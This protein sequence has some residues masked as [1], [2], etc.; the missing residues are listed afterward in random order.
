[1]HLLENQLGK[2]A[3]VRCHEGKDRKVIFQNR[4][5]AGEGLAELLIKYKNDDPLILALPRGGV[6]VAAEVARKLEVPLDVLIVRK[7]GAPFDSEVALGG[8]CE[9]TDALWNKTLL[10]HLALKPEDLKRALSIEKNKIQEQILLFRQGRR[11]GSLQKKFVILID[12]GLATGATMAAAIQYLK[13]KQVAKIVVAVPVAA[14]STANKLRK[15][16]NEL[17]TLQQKQE[18]GSVGKWY[19]NFEQ[20]SDQDVVKILSERKE[21]LLNLADERFVS[22]SKEKNRGLYEAIEKDMVGFKSERDFDRL[23][24]NVKDKRVVMLGEASHG[25]EEFYLVRRLISQ[26]LIKD[27]GFKFIAVEG[28]WPDAYRLHRYIQR[29]EGLD[30]RSVL[31]H[32]HRWPTWM[33]A[34]EETV[35]L[36]ESLRKSKAGFYGLDVY[37]LYESI[38]QVNK[39]IENS[40]PDFLDEFKKS[41]ACFQPFEGDEIS[42]ARSLFRYPP[43]C[44]KE[45]LTNLQ[46]LLSLRLER[47]G[48]QGE[49]LFNSQ[50]NARIVAHA[51][52]YYRA[53]LKGDAASWNIRDHHM[54]DTLSLLLEKQGSGAKAIVWAHN[55]HIGDYRATDMKAAGYV[56]LGGL[57]R[58]KYGDEN[59]A[60]IGFGTYKGEVLAGKAW[61]GPE[62]VMLLPPA[63]NESYEFYFHQVAQAKKTD[64]FY[65]MLENKKEL[66]SKKGHRAVGVV[67]D[68][69]QERQGNYVPTELSKRYDAFV[70]IDQ[71]HAL[72]SLHS[73]F[74]QGEFPDTWPSGL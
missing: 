64:Q 54:M 46:K 61:G 56:N 33:W 8:I 34:N 12:D 42:Y 70:F 43:G 69:G 65:L 66:S 17:I 62:Q 24:Q 16:I 23:I 6:P 35:K 40:Y 9:E 49:E 59:V 30:A 32:N 18:L 5:L 27:H 38:E 28:D 71:T 74:A 51:E 53:M 4:E 2:V 21:N 52:A 22:L 10:S 57:A 25:T 50:Q 19:E 48:L 13:A 7:I 72:K 39:F 63:Q 15:R 44:E 55:T 73:R 37:S 14:K 67:Y 47:G 26:C 31:I 45:A 20:V 1:M 36:A 60:L 41:Y 68:P 58:E 29:G 3:W 11:L